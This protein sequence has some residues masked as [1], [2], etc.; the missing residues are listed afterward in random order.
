M[1]PT[2]REQAA[3]DETPAALSLRPILGEIG[4][5][6]IFTAGTLL[7]RRFERG[8]LIETLNPGAVLLRHEL[9]HESMPGDGNSLEGALQLRLKRSEC[10]VVADQ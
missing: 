3:A 10:G 8:Y 9:G 6:E 7:I 2:E 1:T 5:D 4:A